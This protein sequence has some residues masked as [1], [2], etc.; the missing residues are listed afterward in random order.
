MNA[1]ALNLAAALNAR[2]GPGIVL[3]SVAYEAHIINENFFAMLVLLAIV[4]SLLA[5]S[6]LGSVVRGGGVSAG[7]LL[8]LIIE[9]RSRET[10]KA[11]EA[12]RQQP[13]GREFPPRPPGCRPGVTT[14]DDDWWFV[15]YPRSGNTYWR[16]LTANLIAK[17]RTG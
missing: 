12:L 4:T 13:H 14:F 2:G 1:T 17:W 16:F 5:G 6:W 10:R 8:A 3:A 7:G 15:S 9:D 11:S